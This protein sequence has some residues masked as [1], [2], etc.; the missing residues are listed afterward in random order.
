MSMVKVSVAWFPL[1]AL[2]AF[3]TVAARLV[4]PWIMSSICSSTIRRMKSACC[5]VVA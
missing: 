3:P 5:P 2:R 4:R 1:R